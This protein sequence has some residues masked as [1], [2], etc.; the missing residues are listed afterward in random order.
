[1][2]RRLRFVVGVG[3]GEG[4]GVGRA[5][6]AAEEFALGVILA[7]AGGVREGVVG[8]VDYL[9]LARAGGAFWGVGGDAVGVGF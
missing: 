2:R 8:V 5:A 6:G 7:P 4:I 9:E 1:L 3:V